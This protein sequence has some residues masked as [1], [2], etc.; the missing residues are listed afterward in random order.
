MYRAWLL[1]AWP[2]R[3]RVVWRWERARQ[4]RIREAFCM[5]AED[6]PSEQWI[7]TEICSLA[8]ELSREGLETRLEEVQSEEEVEDY[9]D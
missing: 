3:R 7:K 2:E 6:K 4:E 8:A 5:D 1:E 9:M